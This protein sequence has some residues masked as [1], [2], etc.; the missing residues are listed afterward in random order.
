MPVKCLAQAYSETQFKQGTGRNSAS[1]KGDRAEGG[2]EG[3]L[4]QTENQCA[5]SWA[6]SPSQTGQ[7][8]GSSDSLER[9]TP[10]GQV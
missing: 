4:C 8:R 3:P 5:T 9:V 7:L 1:P 2:Q 10:S 6:P